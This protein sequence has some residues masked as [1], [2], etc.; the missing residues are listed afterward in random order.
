MAFRVALFWSK[1]TQT[2]VPVECAGQAAVATFDPNVAG[3]IHVEA[4]TA[5]VICNSPLPARR[6]RF[7]IMSPVRFTVSDYEY[8]H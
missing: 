3:G 7:A 4:A 1:G 2:R 6:R 5:S 8:F